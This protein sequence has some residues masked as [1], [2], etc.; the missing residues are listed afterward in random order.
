MVPRSRPPHRHAGRQILFYPTA[1]GWHPSEKAEYGEAQHSAWETI[2]R[3]HAVANGFYVAAVNRVGH[4]KR[5]DGGGDGIEF[6]GH[7][8]IADT[9]GQILAKA[10]HD[11]E[12][13]LIAELDP[14]PG[15]HPP[16][17]PFLRDRRI[18]AYA[19]LTNRFIDERRRR[20]RR[21]RRPVPVRIL[22]CPL[23]KLHSTTSPSI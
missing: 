4:E 7:S 1:I 17:W 2:Q 13:I 22:N 6:W 15:R 12:E 16:H 11:K 14:S 8:F 21:R 18:D 23:W 20:R 5:P 19:G 10:S 3:S 9:F